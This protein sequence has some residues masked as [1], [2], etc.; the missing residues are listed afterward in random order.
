VIQCKWRGTKITE[1]EG[2][3]TE[4]ENH[5]SVTKFIRHQVYK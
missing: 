1:A 2:R 5:G 4:E 3:K